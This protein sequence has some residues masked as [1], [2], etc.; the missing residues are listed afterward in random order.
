MRAFLQTVFVVLVEP[1]PGY[2]L[3]DLPAC[4]GTRIAGP[5][6]LDAK[7]LQ[8]AGVAFVDASATGD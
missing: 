6:I 4:F 2:L 8:N 3:S 7:A 5:Y 1:Q